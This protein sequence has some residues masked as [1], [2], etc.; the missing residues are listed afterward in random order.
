M[1]VVGVA[2]DN[3]IVG[4]EGEA[5]A[6]DNFIG[7]G[8]GAAAGAAGS[9]PVVPGFLATNLIVCFAIGGSAACGAGAGAASGAGA[10]AAAGAAGDGAEASL[11]TGFNFIV[12][13]L[14]AAGLASADGI[15]CGIG[16]AGAAGADPEGGFE[17]GLSFIVCF[18][19]PCPMGGIA[20]DFLS[21]RCVE[22]S[23]EAS[24]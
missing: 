11:M 22:E 1:P 5:A 2:G 15:A 16:E 13:I 9:E 21:T 23:S 14:G 8:A 3:F 17:D 4:A 19:A 7:A 12:G 10:G 18:V 20:T 6:G 24:S